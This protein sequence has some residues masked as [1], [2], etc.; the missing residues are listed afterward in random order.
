MSDRNTQTILSKQ[1]AAAYLGISVRTLDRRQAQGD[2]P[3]R[4]KHGGKI[5]FFQCSLVEWLR[6]LERQPVR[7]PR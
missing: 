6:S 5:A 4:I 3:P 7:K 2:G 1:Q